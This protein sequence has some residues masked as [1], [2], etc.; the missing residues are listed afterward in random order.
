MPR[1]RLLMAA[2]C[3][4]PA[5]GSEPWAGWSL[6]KLAAVDHEVT[7]IVEERKF[8]AAIE[9]ALDADPDPNLRFV[10]V[11]ERWWAH[12]MWQ[13]GLGYRSY[14]WWQ[15]R[16]V[17]AAAWL[18]AG[19]PFDAVHASTIISFREPGFWHRLNIPV[20][21][22]PIGGTA[23]VA[24]SMLPVMGLSA[25][26]EWLRSIVN[27]RDRWS[28]RV[29]QMLDRADVVVAATEETRRDLQEV[30]PRSVEVVSEIVVPEE[31]RGAT[32]S[33]RPV[34]DGDAPLRVL[35]SG[36]HEARKALP[37][38]LDAVSRC[39]TTVVVRVLGDGPMNAAWRKSAERFGVA[40]RVEWA[41]WVARD[42]IADHYAWADVFA[43]PSVRD[44]T[45][46]V[47][48]EALA[49]GLPV[50]G[51][52]HQGVA[53][54]VTESCGRVVPF[55]GPS[56]AAAGMAAVIDELADATV[57]ETL[58]AGAIERAADYQPDA[59]LA[60]WRPIWRRALAQS[61]Q[62]PAHVTGL[63]PVRQTLRRVKATL[64]AQAA[65]AV[66]SA[67]PP[68]DAAAVG[69]I[70]YHRIC[71]DLTRRL[72]LNVTPESFERQIAGL[73]EA[74]WQGIT[75]GDICTAYASDAGNAEPLPRKHFAITFD[76]AF[77]N[78]HRFALPILKRYGVPATAYLAT[79]FIGA[80]APFPFDPWNRKGHG[81]PMPWRPLSHAECDD[82]LDAGW[83][84]AVHTAT[85]R[86]FSRVAEEFAAD[87][88]ESCDW[89]RDRYGIDAPT[90]SYPYGLVDDALAGIVRE[91]GCRCGLTTESR[92]VRPGDDPFWW[93]RFGADDGESP[94]MLIGKLSGWF[95]SARGCWRRVAAADE[96]FRDGGET[97]DRTSHDPLAVS[98]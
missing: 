91:Q 14:R 84:L 46:T 77:G 38:L 52:D 8:R 87:L 45:G 55:T 79:R 98:A 12:T 25:P 6:A 82:L 17:D 74:G 80:D 51:L 4:S 28:K 50:V 3:C 53:D 42:A 34:R 29:R 32:P 16:A 27:R 9:A 1:P 49:A 81:D 66:A 30:V 54:V 13:V 36:L 90:F 64:A 75:V 48:L 58:S 47:L 41:G 76:D 37:L 5:E 21:W 70:N 59:K 7:V 20:I 78:V 56:D 62:V 73:V 71:P 57:R 85:H 86:D 24:S 18:H 40:D 44:T 10:F 2:Y 63:S 92:L 33:A 83:E 19:R 95:E 89:L 26:K 65:G 67:L 31:L 11:P 88:G 23:D 97:E 94:R 43:F 39:R 68:R 61:T 22:G 60:Q 93:G 35:F 72:P 15:R 96:T 69:I